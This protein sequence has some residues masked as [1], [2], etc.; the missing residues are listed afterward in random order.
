MAIKKRPTYTAEYRKRLVDLVR[1]GRTTT[2]LSK[3]FG[4][5][6]TAIRTWWKRAEV[7]D[8][9]VDG[10]TTDERSELVRLRRENATL[11]EE[12]EI[13]KKFAAWSAQEANWTPSKRSGS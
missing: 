13:L 2:S 12:R 8:G 5:S 4:I 9:V 7:D 11:R 10:V 3:E 6:A 1:A